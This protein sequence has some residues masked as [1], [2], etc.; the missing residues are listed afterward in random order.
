MKIAILSRGPRLYSTRR[1]R[2]ALVNR[3]H[4]VR[5]LNPL[6]F[7][8]L[9]DEDGP[10]LL[11]RNRQLEH[12]D[13][14]V[15]RVGAS[16]SFYGTAVVRQFEQMG[17]YSLNPSHAISVA[18]DKL[19]ASQVFSRH[20]IGIPSTA[21]VRRRDA[22][23][24]A[25][26]HTGGAPVI[27]KLLEGTQ[28]VGV[29]L[30]DSTKM[31][32]AI[33]ET[34]QKTN[35]NVLIQNF[36]RESRGTDIRA[37][38]VGGRVVGAMRRRAVGQEFRSNVHRGGKPEA[39][40]LEKEYERTAIRA[41]QILGLRVAGVDMLE[42]QDGPKIM[43]VNASPGL[44]G[45]EK[46]TET[47]IADEIAAF[48]EQNVH[49]PDVDIQQRLTLDR[50]YGVVELGVEEQSDFAGKSIGESGLREMDILILSILRG[51]I[52]IPAPRGDERLLPGDVLI[53]FGKLLT[54]TT[55][56]PRRRATPSRRAPRPARDVSP[57]E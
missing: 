43:E 30:A 34:L 2:E 48:L 13:A 52:S 49:F 44:E 19:R 24:P 32:E 39:V 29:I 57:A 6:D 27:V 35:Q 21:I 12:Y 42:G 41:A 33:V 23:L 50:G 56:V 10:G 47:D 20:D 14:I 11:Y 51:G 26:D 25:I 22:I 4:K 31:A 54:L 7:T 36:V 15:P 46:A 55:L 45:I 8:I 3:G 37:F 28:G 16:I 53:C 38:V 5:V 40:E 1:I 17:V 18:R 9:V